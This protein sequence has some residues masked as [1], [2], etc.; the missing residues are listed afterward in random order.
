[1][2]N[3]IVSGFLKRMSRSK[4]VQIF[5]VYFPVVVDYAIE[6]RLVVILDYRQTRITLNLEA[7]DKLL[8][9]IR[10]HTHLN[11]HS[12]IHRNGVPEKSKVS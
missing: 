4:V 12:G 2:E 11:K 1:M 8:I 5:I 6:P 3:D 9:Q 7:T 10:N